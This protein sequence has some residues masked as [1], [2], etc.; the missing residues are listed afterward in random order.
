MKILAP[1]RAR[2]RSRSSPLLH[3][4][5]LSAGRHRASRRR[6][7][8]SRRTAASFASDG[9]TRGLGAHR[10]AVRR[11][12]ATSGAA[13]RRRRR[14][15][16]T[17]P[18]R[19]AR[20][21]ARRTP[22]LLDAAKARVDALRAADPGNDAPDPGRPR[23]GLGQRARSA[24]QP[25]GRG[26][27]GR[28]RRAGARARRRP[29]SARSSQRTRRGATARRPR[30]AARQRARAEP[31]ARCELRYG[32]AMNDRDAAAGSRRAPPQRVQAEAARARRGQLKIF[33]GAA[34]GV[35]KTYAMLEAALARDGRRASTSSSASSRRT[36][37]PKRQTLARR[38]RDRCRAKIVEYRG[39]D[40]RGVR[41]RRGARAQARASCSSTSSRTRTRPARATRSAG[42]TSIELARRGHRR[43][44]DAERPAHREPQR[45][46][47]ADHRRARARDGARLGLRARRRDRARR[48]AARRAAR[49]PARGQGLRAEQA[50]R[51]RREL[52]PQGQP[53]RAA[54]ARAAHARPSASTRDVL[55]YRREHGIEATWPAAE[56]I[57]V[58][59]GPSPA[60]G[61]SRARGA[62]H[63]GRPAR[64]LD[65][66]RRRDAGDGASVGAGPRARLGAPAARRGARRRRCDAQRA[67]ARARRS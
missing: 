48:S 67:S 15:P 32:D 24:H 17:P 40:A 9:K 13:R 52:L 14:S 55:A 36:A 47:R 64:A 5:R 10:P 49:A 58:C 11:S 23:D 35:G 43:L 29:R 16:T 54:R 57:L 4:R 53:D 2:A 7:S 50:A 56:R 31:R 33:F 44:H 60:S 12:D 46:R 6:P 62:A 19:P 30:R 26:V 41:P 20:T 3:G 8:R 21:S 38:A 1:P 61:G 66:R 59:I 27:P 25:G 51:A 63:G 22:R 34:P 18:R 42:R 37:A 39:H 28:A 65:R 45:R